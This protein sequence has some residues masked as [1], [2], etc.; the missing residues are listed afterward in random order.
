MAGDWGQCRWACLLQG[1]SQESHGAAASASSLISGGARKQHL[2]SPRG[3][4]VD[5][6]PC[7]QRAWGPAGVS[8]SGAILGHQGPCSCPPISRSD[9]DLDPILLR[10]DLIST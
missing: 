2:L 5:F 6:A 9:M 8:L 3:G 7:S 4:N 10:Y 1:P